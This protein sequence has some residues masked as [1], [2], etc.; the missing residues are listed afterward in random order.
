MSKRMSAASRQCRDALVRQDEV[1]GVEVHV[2][3]TW[4]CA[5]GSMRRGPRP[6]RGGAACRLEVVGASLATDGILLAAR[7]W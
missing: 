2:R 7:R 6:R 3:G 5:E 1:V 4:R